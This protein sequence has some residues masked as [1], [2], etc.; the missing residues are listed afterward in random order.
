[1]VYLVTTQRQLF[2]TYKDIT[3]CSVDKSLSVLWFLDSIGVDT[4][5]EGLDCH[6]DGLICLQLGDKNNQFVID[7][8]SVS[9]A[10]YKDLLESKE[11]ILHNAKFDLKF[12]YKNNIWPKYIYDTFLA[13]CVLTT[14]LETR[15]LSLESVCL[16]Y[17]NRQL[18]KDI[19]NVIQKER[20]SSRV[21]LYSAEDV[22]Y[23]HEIK[24]KQLIKIKHYNLEETLKLENEVVKVFAKMEFDGVLLNSKKWLEISNK[25]ELE[26]T[27]LSKELDLIVESEPKLSKYIPKYVQGDLFGEPNKNLNINWSS[28]AQKLKI[29]KTLGLNVDSVDER[30]LLKNK[31]NHIIVSKLL[32]YSKQ[33]KLATAF[34]KDF[35]KFINP[36]TKRIHPDIWQILSTGRISVSKPNLNQIPSKGDLGKEIRSCFI[37]AKDNVIVGGD[38][39]GM[40]LRIIAEFSQ[41]P[42]WLDSFNNKEDLHS[43]LCS[44]T[45]DIP[46][47]DVKKETPFKKGVTYRDVQKTVNFGLAY[48]MSKFKLADTI[49]IS[50]DEADKIIKKFFSVVPKV[51]SFL[52]NLGD[53][54]KKRGY[55]KTSPPYSRIRWF[56]NWKYAIE[57]DNFKIL[58]E[59]ER[60]AKNTPIQGTNGDCIKQ[61]LVNAQ[62]YIDE[63]KA[64][65]KIILAVYDEIQTE[66]DEDFADEWKVIL[67]NIMKDAAKIIIKSIPV[68]VDCKISKYWTK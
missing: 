62:K 64:P 67:E 14:G 19:R 44:K 1:M 27:N 32:D 66:C 15:E 53:L 50:V 58:G 48:G 54:G 52:N 24:E 22:E 16:N 43:V 49:D 13:E 34:G 45:F 41:D 59:I 10:C 2:E 23:L 60:A 37:P 11:L 56:E 57:N 30:T 47:T 31:R 12:L 38:Y 9:I 65:V 40:E 6:I 5:T 63:N 29:L 46:I 68:E 28:N 55:I 7:L 42:L 17:C 21:I 61:A 3:I 51:N 39:S 35:L 25:V 8:E 4:E 26:V 33:A 18:N 36:I 20:L